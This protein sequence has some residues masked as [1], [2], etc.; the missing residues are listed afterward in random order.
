MSYRFAGNENET[1]H[2][3]RSAVGVATFRSGRDLPITST[4]RS[5]KKETNVISALP[6]EWRDRVLKERREARRA[7]ANF[8]AVCASGDADALYNASR[9]LNE[10]SHNARCLAM[11]RV[12]RLPAVSR[13]IQEAFLSIWIEHKHLSLATGNRRVLL[14]ALRKLLPC[15]YS[16]PSL[17]LYRGTISTE[18]RRRL[19]GFSWSTDPG[20]ARNF[21]HGKVYP[22]LQIEG[23]VLLASVSAEAILLVRKPE[24]YYDEGEVVVDPFLI[25]KVKVVELI[26]S[27]SSPP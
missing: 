21:A 17:T 4:R 24:D 7:A 18:R 2:G 9:W 14:T 13:D 3:C 12:G 16:G 10:S 26:T 11:A 27:P 20:I 25:G 19:Y 1:S 22:E 15:D 8:A 6:P 5:A 23:V